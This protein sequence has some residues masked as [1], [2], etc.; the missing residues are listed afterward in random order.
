MREFTSN[1][2]W[3]YHEKTVTEKGTGKSFTLTQPKTI[4]N[5]DY[6]TVRRAIAIDHCPVDVVP[7][8]DFNVVEFLYLTGK[9][10]TAV[11]VVDYVTAYMLIRENLG[12][13][14]Q[15]AALSDIQDFFEREG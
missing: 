3:K 4:F 11:K 2:R 1:G 13:F 14:M 7:E 9:G 12:A 10:S 5:E 15:G 6:Y 8:R